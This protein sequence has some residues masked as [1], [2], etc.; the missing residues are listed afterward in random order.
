MVSTRR[1]FLGA[2]AAGGALAAAQFARAAGAESVPAIPAVKIYKIYLGGRGR[3]W[4]KPEFDNEAEVAR[5][6]KHLAQAAP[7][8]PGIELV[9]G[10]LALSPNDIAALL[11]KIKET[12]GV[13]AVHLALGTIHE[14]QAIVDAG[15][16]TVVFS[17]PFSGHEWMFVQGWANAGKKVVL[18]ATS[19]LGEIEG[20][21]RLLAVPERLRRSRLVA[22]GQAGTPAACDRTK[23]LERL[24]VD[25]VPLTLERLGEAHAGADAAAAR[26][27]ADTWIKGAKKV[28]EPTPDEIVKSAHMYLAMRRILAEERAQAITI[29][30]LG[31]VP[32]DTM[33]YPCLG[34]TELLDEGLVG[35]CESDMDS[36]LTMLMATYAFGVPGFITDPLFDTAKNA[37]I[38]AHCTAPTKMDGPAGPRAPYLIRTHRDDNRGAALEVEMRVG[39]PITCA[40]LVNLDTMLLSGGTITEI[41]DIDDRGCRTQITTAV[42]DAHTMMERWGGGL[43]EGWVQQ[44]HRVVF[45]GDH[46]R[47]MTRLG[48]LMGYKIYRE[49]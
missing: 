6:E 4:P 21:V 28:V 35:A 42:A 11:P 49:I 33:G 23:V 10:E 1:E 27:L 30:C 12:A 9:G 39:Q 15:L 14:L 26:A 37:V 44:L 7:K 36:T 18:L 16:P 29:N 2:A 31:G 32:I 43:V 47:D 34:F 20:A 5:I 41:T 25:V 24:G 13:L 22:Y 38:H 19:D 48:A 45:Y 46:V 40:K 3:A 17:Q 8:M